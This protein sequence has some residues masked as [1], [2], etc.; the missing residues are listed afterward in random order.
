MPALKKYRPLFRDI[1]G[2]TNVT[3]RM[4]VDELIK[5]TSETDDEQNEAFEYSKE[6]LNDIA[7]LRNYEDAGPA[8]KVERCWPCRTPT[9]GRMFCSIGSFFVNDR[10]GLFK[11]FSNIHTFLDFDFDA[12]RKFTK[13][14]RNSDCDDF[15]ST[16][17]VVESE[18]RGSLHREDILTQNF[19]YR[20]DAL[21]K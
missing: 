19:R 8:L 3:T 15:L 21:A 6:L 9:G 1:L 10:D 14:L 7:R 17:V 11:I 13:M 20:A 12:T 18:V 5:I 4:L 16:E 2:V